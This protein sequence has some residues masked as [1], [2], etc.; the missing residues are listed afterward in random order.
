[1]H[2]PFPGLTCRESL[3]D[4]VGHTL[5]MTMPLGRDIS[6]PVAE[7]ADAAHRVVS[8]RGRGSAKVFRL[9]PLTFRLTATDHDW[10]TG[11]S[12]EVTGAMTDLFLLL[13]G[14]VTRIEKLGGPGADQLCRAVAI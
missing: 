8:Y 14:R 3:I 12:T 1:M 2:R 10:S 5:G 6:I 4:A 13:T 9:L 11:D 7:V